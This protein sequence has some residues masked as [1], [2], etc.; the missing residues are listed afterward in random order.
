MTREDSRIKMVLATAFVGLA[1]FATATL[2]Q[3]P[4]GYPE[5]YEEVIAAANREGRL[6]VYSVTSSVPALLED[7]R[8]LYPGV[9]LE[10]V[11]LDT[12]PAY[13]RVVSEASRGST[14]DVAWS[15]AMDLQVKLVSDG[16]AMPYA[17][18]EA[19]N[20]PSWAMWRN[21]AYGSTYEPIGFVYNKDLVAASEV[22]RTRADLVKLLADKPSKFR[23]GITA[24]DPEKSGV[25]YLMMAQDAKASPSTFWSVIH[26]LGANGLYPGTGSG[27]QF[28][29]LAKG[30]SLIGYNLL[31]SYAKGRIKHDLPNLAVVLPSDYTLVMTRV[32]FISKNAAHPNA[33]KLWIDYLLSKRGQQILAKADLGSLRSDVEDEATP[34]ALGKRPG[35]AVRPIPVSADLLADLQ[36]AQRSKFLQQWTAEVSNP[37][38]K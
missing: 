28:E 30:E 8:K 4:A 27:A 23:D 22:P 31:T 13:D 36:P 32:M 25:G 10:Y 15:S 37:R 17:S 35:L 18:P 26:A 5:S 29:R 3:R 9:Q 7:F 21:E 1:C 34:V 11:A 38:S 33:A 20:L 12:T 16:Y 24:F 19:P 2:A 6:I 14:A